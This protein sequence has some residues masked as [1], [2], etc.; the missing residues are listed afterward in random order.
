MNL[1]IAAYQ[2]KYTYNDLSSFFNTFT[3]KQQK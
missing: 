1:K 3:K 2:G